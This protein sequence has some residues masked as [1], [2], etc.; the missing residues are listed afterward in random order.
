MF[1]LPIWCRP[2]AW[3]L[4]LLGVVQ[5]A[6]FADPPRTLHVLVVAD[7]TDPTIGSDVK[8]DREN[9]VAFLNQ[10]F[11]LHL[12]QLDCRCLQGPLSADRLF[13]ALEEIKGQVRP[14]EDALL[15]YFSGHGRRDTQ[16]GHVLKV[17][18][19]S[20]PRE[21][22]RRRM[23]EAH[24][25]LCLLV[26]DSCN[27]GDRQ[28]SPGDL[29]TETGVHDELANWETIRC[30]F[31]E[32]RG[33]LDVNA[34]SEGQYALCD[35]SGS[36]FTKVLLSILRRPFDKLDH[37]GDRFLHWEEVLHLVQA[38]ARSD[39]LEAKPRALQAIASAIDNTRGARR[40]HLADLQATLQDQKSQDMRIWSMPS[41]QRFGVHAVASEHTRVTGN[42]ED[43]NI[44]V[45]RAVVTE[46]V[47]V[48]GDI[49]PG[50]PADRAGLK[51][52]DIL[53]SLNG[54]S[55]VSVAQLREQVRQSQ[56]TVS[57]VYRRPP[58]TVQ[59]TC[60]V[61]LEPWPDVNGK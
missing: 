44:H 56:G 5:A 28:R 20:V 16:D 30:L 2:L 61:V 17:G 33:T 7:T 4:L 1:I 53:L 40:A 47:I 18:D 29:M 6:A 15:V 59:Q 12:H 22:I 42:G 26:T 36:I 58:S 31:L 54:H 27:H 57:V 39:F 8:I 38:Q 49:E 48:V 35:P 34:S 25:R 19:T 51:V 43:E 24:P 60:N 9:V 55:V 23:E 32:S 13:A 45:W 37:D 3:S 14:H 52:G 10:G 46:E 11:A 21:M 50:S 41:R